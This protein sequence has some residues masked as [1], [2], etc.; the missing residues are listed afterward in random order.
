MR[1]ITHNSDV[2]MHPGSVIEMKNHKVF[3]LI[4]NASIQKVIPKKIS[5]DFKLETFLY[6][7]N[8]KNNC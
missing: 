5:I 6:A 4:L 8:M 1:N 2:Y 7:L 3:I